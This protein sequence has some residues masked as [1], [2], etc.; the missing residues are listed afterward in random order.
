MTRCLRIVVRRWAGRA[1]EEILLVVG[2]TGSPRSF[3]PELQRALNPRTGTWIG[4]RLPDG[5]RRC[6][7]RIFWCN[8]C[9]VSR[10][11]WTNQHVRA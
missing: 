1:M 2:R 5:R 7:S 9:I 4:S 10:E 8:W 6:P 11:G 3:Y